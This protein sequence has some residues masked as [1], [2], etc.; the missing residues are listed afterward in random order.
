MN[1]TI[2]TDGACDIHL[3]NRPGGW[4][5]II[6]A[7]DEN[8]MVI[9]EAVLSGGA[10][11][12][13]NNQMELRAVIEGLKAL[14][15]RSVVTIV[16]D[17]RYVID[18]S[19]EKEPIET[20]PGLWRD[21]KGLATIHTI[22]WNLASGINAKAPF[23]ERCKQLASIEMQKHAL[24]HIEEEVAHGADYVDASVEVYLASKRT[25]RIGYTAW[26]ALI[27][28]GNET[29]ILGAV[30]QD[31][32]SYEALLNGVITTLE[33][34]SRKSPIKIYTT[35]QNLVFGLTIVFGDGSRTTGCI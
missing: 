31:A 28:N 35:Q 32:T 19:A 7:M 23:Q 6:C 12:T 11:H 1:I 21:F 13:T 17:S 22:S 4:A 2:Y 20:D 16:T 5:S 30:D 26:A 24:Y 8:G 27:L 29:E 33:C 10:E 15:R 34:L 25:A 14:Q 18:T 3:D 9:K